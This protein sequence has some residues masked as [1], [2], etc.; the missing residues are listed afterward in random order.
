MK[1]GFW[2]SFIGSIPMGYLN[3]IAL[4]IFANDSWSGLLGF[5]L[6]VI[7]V[8]FWVI[9]FT[10]W[11]AEKLLKNT[12]VLFWIDVF[13]VVFLAGL[14]FSCLPNGQNLP[15]SLPTISAT[16]PPI[17]WGIWFNGLNVMQLSFWAGWNVFLLE[18]K[19]IKAEALYFY[20]IGALLGTAIGMVGFVLLAHYFLFTPSDYVFFALFLLLA[21]LALINLVWKR[22]A[23]NSAPR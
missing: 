3:L 14:A 16:V 17:L 21:V 22:W 18:K 1:I 5:V 4:K 10:F 13:A 23:S 12:K 11:G 15:T 8:E 2:I 9:Y 7:L 19:K 20:I 6:G